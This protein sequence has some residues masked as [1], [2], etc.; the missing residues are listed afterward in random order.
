[1][2]SN[3]EQEKIFDRLLDS[4]IFNHMQ[5]PELRSAAPYFDLNNFKKG[6]TIFKEGD[7]DAFMCFLQSGRVLMLKFDK[8]G[9]SV[10]I[11]TEC[12]GHAFGEMAVLDGELHSVTCVAETDC[13]LLILEK[14]S[15]DAMLNDKPGI[16]AEILRVIAISLSRRIR[17]S[18]GILVNHL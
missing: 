14:S 6:A 1:M 10:A 9:D 5:A 3:A 4:K 11:G 13:E 17:A 8:N 12:A 16:G 2:T 15:M 7:K 18:A